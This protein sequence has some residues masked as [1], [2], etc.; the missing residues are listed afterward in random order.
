[1]QQPVVE[2]GRLARMPLSNSADRENVRQYQNLLAAVQQPVTDEEARL[3]VT[4]FGPDDYFGLVW[5]LVHLVERAP[6]WPIQDC[7]EDT[8][9]EWIRLLGQRMQNA[10]RTNLRRFAN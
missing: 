2:L 8:E 1:M 6:G 9:N 3:L 5:P 7:L 10:D 4:L